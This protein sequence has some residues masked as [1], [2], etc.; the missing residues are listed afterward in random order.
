MTRGATC[1]SPGRRAKRVPMENLQSV[2]GRIPIAQPPSSAIPREDSWSRTCS[3]L[4]R[5]D[6]PVP[7]VVGFMIIV[8]QFKRPLFPAVRGG[9]IALVLGLVACNRFG[10]PRYDAPAVQGAPQ[11]GGAAGSST[12]TGD[13]GGASSPVGA[14]GP[15][16][17]G[18]GGFADPGCD[19]CMSASCCL[20]EAA[21]ASDP[22]CGRVESCVGDC[23]DD[24]ACVSSCEEA[25]GSSRAAADLDAC[26]ATSCS[27]ACQ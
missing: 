1:G 18:G 27:E 3:L 5:Q 17:C 15:G 23:T 26:L 16:P 22:S 21:C 7:G 20:E 24:A 25:Y 8:L 19:A 14:P 4:G 11:G 9:A 12:D 13:R 2:T 10:H 6:R